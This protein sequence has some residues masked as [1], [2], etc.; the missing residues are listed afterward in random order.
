MSRV[1]RQFLAIMLLLTAAA[2][3]QVISAQQRFVV[4]VPSRLSLEL[5]APAFTQSESGV[6]VQQSVQV[7]A[8]PEAG[9]VMAV[10]LQQPG[11]IS[12]VQQAH[13]PQFPSAESIQVSPGVAHVFDIPPAQSRSGLERSSRSTTPVIF[14]S[15]QDGPHYLTLDVQFRIEHAKDAPPE[16]LVTTFTSIP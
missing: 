6:L 11:N 8:T 9:M 3:A 14:S 1:A 12:Q 4:H 16:T 13:I 7:K 10:H 15:I 2:H 5:S